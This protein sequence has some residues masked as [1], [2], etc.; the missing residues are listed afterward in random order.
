M[1]EA[2][3]A[4]RAAYRCCLKRTAIQDHK[5]ELGEREIDQGRI[6]M[7]GRQSLGKGVIRGLQA[8]KAFGRLE[9][10]KPPAEQAA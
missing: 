3:N 10:V 2:A 1:E 9:T 4:V 7:G 6:K 5:T 8:P